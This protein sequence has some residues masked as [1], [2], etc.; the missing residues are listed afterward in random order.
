MQSPRDPD[1]GLVKKTW[2]FVWTMDAKSADGAKVTLVFSAFDAAYGVYMKMWGWEAGKHWG[3]RVNL[4]KTYG[5]RPF[6]KVGDTLVVLGQKSREKRLSFFDPGSYK[7]Q[8]ILNSQDENEFAVLA[9]F[10]ARDRVQSKL[11]GLAKVIQC[12]DASSSDDLAEF[13]RFISRIGW[14]FT[15]PRDLAREAVTRAEGEKDAFVKFCWH[16]IAWCAGHLPSGIEARE[17]AATIRSWPVPDPKEMLSTGWSR[18]HPD[19]VFSPYVGDVKRSLR[20]LQ[21]AAESR[22]QAARWYCLWACGGWQE[23]FQPLSIK[24]LSDC[25]RENDTPSLKAMLDQLDLWFPGKVIS[26]QGTEVRLIAEE[27]LR[28]LKAR[29]QRPSSD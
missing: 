2:D 14:Q 28:F 9:A 25:L 12:L 1:W 27:W 3:E 23:S 24:I 26:P 13:S 17:A 5:L 7:H 21:A 22:T 29:G 4:V 16:Y 6:P 11:Q 15:Y 20:T 10:K 8:V 18:L 19:D